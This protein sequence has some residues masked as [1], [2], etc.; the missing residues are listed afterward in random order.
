MGSL[1]LGIG[2]LM[3]M[4]LRELADYQVAQSPRL[5]EQCMQGPF[6]VINA[7]RFLEFR[8]WIDTFVNRHP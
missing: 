7:W 5:W 6:S 8:V 1:V 3:L 2:S 4:S